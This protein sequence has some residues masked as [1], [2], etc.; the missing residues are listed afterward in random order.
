MPLLLALLLAS[1]E[2]VTRRTEMLAARD[3][4]AIVHALQVQS[5]P[6]AAQHGRS[7]I[8]VRDEFSSPMPVVQLWSNDNGYWSGGA[9]GYSG[10][11]LPAS[12]V[13]FN[14]GFPEAL[15]LVPGVLLR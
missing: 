5:R 8:V 13:R 4:N 9:G 12:S 15:R 3:W 14:G 1:P 7:P 2:A 6:L 11:Y 10:A